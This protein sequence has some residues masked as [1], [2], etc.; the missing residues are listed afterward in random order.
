MAQITLDTDQLKDLF[1]EDNPMRLLLEEV[2][3]TVLEAEM[4]EHLGAKRYER[5]EKRQ[6]Y[7]NGKRERRLSTRVG[8]L[9]LRVPQC[10][11]GSFSTE[12]F[13]RYQRSEQA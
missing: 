9:T 8:T 7:R 2:L 10:R 6:A 11:D 12:L 5:T 3:N 13:S 4:T 1:S